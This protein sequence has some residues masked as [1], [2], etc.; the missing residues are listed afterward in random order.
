MVKRSIGEIVILGLVLGVLLPFVSCQASS[1]LVSGTYWDGAAQI[2]LDQEY[3][4]GL[5]DTKIGEQEESVCQFFFSGIL[6][7]KKA[8]IQIRNFIDEEPIQ[9]EVTILSDS[10]L[11]IQ[12]SENPG[13]SERIADFQT[14][15]KTILLTK[16]QQAI[17][18]RVIKGQK[19]YFYTR[20]RSQ[21][22]N[23]YL[24][25]GNSVLVS[26]QKEDWLK[27]TYGK[28]VGWIEEKHFY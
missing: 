18:V 11:Q 4:T 27:V 13:C 22:R 2:F 1:N 17:Q 23:A 25:Q 12:T 9:G 26:E 20:P 10:S 16:K 21:K 15:A 5:I 24:I 6:S 8:K 7:G 19:V 3:L 28:T 14:Q